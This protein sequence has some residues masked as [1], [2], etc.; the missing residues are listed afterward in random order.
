MTAFRTLLIILLT[1]LMGYTVVVIANHG[2]G[3]FNI[4]FGDMAVI[5]W[6][7]QFNL[8]FMFMLILS[9]FWVAWRHQ[10]S[11]IGILLS[12]LALLGGSLFLTIYLLILSWQFNGN[13]KLVLLGKTR[14]QE[15]FNEV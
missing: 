3:L 9:A 12:V 15:D 7:G 14:A 5:G 8:D 10:F 1:I 11:G 13:M 4:F 2:L 6:A